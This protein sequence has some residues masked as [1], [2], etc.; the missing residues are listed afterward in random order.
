MKRYGI[1]VRLPPD[2]PM[3][4]AHLLGEDWE[5][6]HW[7]DRAEERDRAYEQ[8]QR[9]PAYYRSGDTPSQILTKIERE[10]D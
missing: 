8:M 7:Y 4:R 9:Q 1:S 2:D 3:C 10:Q 6:L 5:A